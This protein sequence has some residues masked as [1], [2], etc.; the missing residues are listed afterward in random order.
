MKKNRSFVIGGVLC[1]FFALVAGCTSSKLVDIWSDSSF[2]PPSLNKMLVI[3]VSKNSVQRRIWE[4]AFS[5]ELVKHHNIAAT[6]SYH[7][8]PDAVP[9]TNNMIQIIQSNGFDGI[10]ICRR[11]PPETNT[12]YIE[13]Y[14]TTEQSMR[15][16]RRRERFVTYYRNIEHAAYI[17]SQKV[18]IRTIDVW[19]TRNEGQMIWSAT[20][21][22]P[23]PNSV[24]EVRPEIV[25]LVMSE[26]TQQGII[27]PER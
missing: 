14:V 11:L 21:L 5:V 20:S 25:K 16:D 13:G 18:D 27:A 24:Q 4:D 19:A 9:D 7:I 6:A 17:D 23:E 3:S 12:Q 15:Y 2:Q 26:L 22:T 8:F 10:L 1:C